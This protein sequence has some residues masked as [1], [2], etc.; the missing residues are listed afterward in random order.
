E[1][2]NFK[3]TLIQHI[4]SVKKSI[5]ERT[6]HKREYDN[7][8]NERHMQTQEGKVDMVKALDSSLVITKAV[9]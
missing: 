4:S 9:G 1:V 7:R 6:C 5:A 8:L 3:D 2:Q